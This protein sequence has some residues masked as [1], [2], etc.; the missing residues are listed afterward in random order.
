[1]LKGTS[2]TKEAPASTSRPRRALRGPGDAKREQKRSDHEVTPHVAQPPHA[3]IPGDVAES[4]RASHPEARHPE[5]RTDHRADH[6]PEEGQCEHVVDSLQ[7]AL[8]TGH[9]Q[10]QIGAGERLQRVAGRDPQHTDQRD[11]GPRVGRKSPQRHGRPES[12]APDQKRGK[13]DSGRSPYRGDA[14]LLVRKPQA[15][16]CGAEIGGRDQ[17][18]LDRVS[19]QL[20]PSPHPGDR[21]EKAGQGGVRSLRLVG[22]AGH[23]VRLEDSPRFRAVRVI[24]AAGRYMTAAGS[25]PPTG[26]L[27]PFRRAVLRRVGDPG[28]E[29][30][31]SSLSE[32][33]SNRLS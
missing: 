24:R 28:L 7:R 12:I 13:R 1:M 31:T 3:P 18:H 33:R 10:Q 32:K 17:K 2:S 14:A 9:A 20:A 21:L 29:P 19:S 30:G 5:R 6:S 25:V 15:K 23:P 16:L 4:G 27:C 8:K 22:I 11:A 26:A